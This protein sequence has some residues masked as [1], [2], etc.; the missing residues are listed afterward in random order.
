[1]LMHASFELKKYWFTVEIRLY[2]NLL[3]LVFSVCVAAVK[4][5]PVIHHCVFLVLRDHGLHVVD[6]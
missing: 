2:V 4:C 3:H 1:M 5:R 6:I